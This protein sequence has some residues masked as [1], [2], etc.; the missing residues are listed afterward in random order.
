MSIDKSTSN[1][2][3]RRLAPSNPTRDD[4]N[5]SL[6]ILFY[7]T[8]SQQSIHRRS[9]KKSNH[10]LPPLRPSQLFKNGA[11]VGV[12]VAVFV[13]EADAV[14]AVGGVVDDCDVGGSLCGAE[15]EWEEE[16]DMEEGLEESGRLHFFGQ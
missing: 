11:L 4:E 2:K 7:N 13:Q 14:E 9:Q 12:D 1:R 16:D 6:I 10:P 3:T 5:Q 8:Q 15:G